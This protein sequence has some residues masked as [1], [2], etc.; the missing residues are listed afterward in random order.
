ML[1]YALYVALICG[2]L[3]IAALGHVL[4]AVA[5]YETYFSGTV[6]PTSSEYQ[7]WD[8]PLMLRHHASVQQPKL[9]A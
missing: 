8:E 9:A 7:S 6:A 4:M 3:A 2:F 1:A 5:V